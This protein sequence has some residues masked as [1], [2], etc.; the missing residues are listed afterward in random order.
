MIVHFVF[1]IYI[2]IFFK[3]RDHFGA[4]TQ[5]QNERKG[6]VTLDYRGGATLTTWALRQS[7]GAEGVRDLNL[8][9]DLKHEFWLE[10][11]AKVRETQTSVVQLQGSEFCHQPRA[12]E[13]YSSSG[14]P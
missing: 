10:G 8:E 3:S 12:L 6:G 7:H 1:K 13:G 11:G 5:T 9:G 14:P 4:G 2:L